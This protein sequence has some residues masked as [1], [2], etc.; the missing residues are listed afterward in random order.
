MIDNPRD[1][2]KQNIL[3]AVD[4]VYP[5]LSQSRSNKVLRQIEN[6]NIF[7]GEVEDCDSIKNTKKG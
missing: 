1:W 5:I 4:Q 7:W 3:Q 6:R 2:I